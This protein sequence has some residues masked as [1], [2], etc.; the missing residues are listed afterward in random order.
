MSN[1]MEECTVCLQKFTDITLECKHSF[2][3][4]CIQQWAKINK[5]CPLCRAPFSTK[6]LLT[7]QD[8]LDQNEPHHNL[9]TSSVRP[10]EDFLYF[11]RLRMFGG[12]SYDQ[13]RLKK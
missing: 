8:W 4:F 12:T 9:G 6:E 11:E 5:S 3:K 7:Y 1:K 2:H 13:A 10:S